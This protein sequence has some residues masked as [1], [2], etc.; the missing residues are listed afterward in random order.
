M[1]VLFKENFPPC[2]H[3][4]FVQMLFSAETLQA[5]LPEHKILDRTNDLT[6]GN[7]CH[8]TKQCQA[9]HMLVTFFRHSESTAPIFKS[10]KDSSDCLV[11][12]LEHYLSI[13]Q[14][15]IPSDLCR[16][17]KRMVLQDHRSECMICH[18]DIATLK[19]D[20]EM[21][22]QCGNCLCHNCLTNLL[23]MSVTSSE[24]FSQSCPLCQKQDAFRGIV[25]VA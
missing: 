19:V 20:K 8:L 3:T 25:K 11:F 15:V 4:S 7:F 24:E 22:P 13:C 18:D 21:C 14:D 23:Q 12:H 6:L 2:L 16:L 17:L 9:D 10:L 5:C 1:T